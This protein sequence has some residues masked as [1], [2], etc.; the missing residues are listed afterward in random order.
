MPEYILQFPTFPVNACYPSSAQQLINLVAKTGTLKIS[1]PENDYVASHV[2]PGS[3]Q[4]SYVWF[5]TSP[6]AGATGYGL[7][8]VARLFSS[9]RWFEFAQLAQGDRI[10]VT[11]TSAIVAPWG[12]FGFTYSFGDTNILPYSPTAAPAPP[13]G[14]FKYKTYV[15]YWSTKTP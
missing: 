14:G 11:A 9:L 4:Q 7:P 2:V 13:A 5:Q 12:E 1:G 10:L 15:G 3:T 8:K 6:P